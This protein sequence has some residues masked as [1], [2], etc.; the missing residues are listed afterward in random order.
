MLN[1]ITYEL[2]TVVCFMIVFLCLIVCSMYI[3]FKLIDLFYLIILIIYT[4]RY[5]KR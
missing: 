1:K 5:I 4:Y 2:Y 3:N